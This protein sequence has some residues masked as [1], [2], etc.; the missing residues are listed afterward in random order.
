MANEAM[1]QTNQPAE[2]EL[3]GTNKAGEGLLAAGGIIGALLTS[4]CC[5]APLVLFGLGV[6]GAWIANLTALAPYQPIFLTLTLAFLAGGYVMVYRKSKTVY[7]V[8]STCADPTSDKIVKVALWTAT[9]LVLA[10][11]T[12]SF[13]A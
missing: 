5:V 12:V 8:G 13:A 7:V 9:I 1:K 4:A 11:I 10:A 2:I 6:S 3:T